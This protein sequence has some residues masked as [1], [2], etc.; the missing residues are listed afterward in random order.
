MKLFTGF[1]M[2][3][4]LLFACVKGATA[5]VPE[6]SQ[7]SNLAVP[8]VKKQEPASIVVIVRCKKIIALAVVD[9]L[10]IAHNTPLEGLTQG[11]VNDILSTVPA[12]RITAYTID[13]GDSDGT[14]F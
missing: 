12:E 3:L 7:A 6:Q 13:C 5:Q 9:N 4:I 8:E 11:I 1:M 14:I 10:G 2:F